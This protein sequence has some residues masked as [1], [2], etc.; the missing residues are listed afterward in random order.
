MTWV[1][2][3]KKEAVH[4][5]EKSSNPQSSLSSEA[6]VYRYLRLASQAGRVTL[7]EHEYSK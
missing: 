1:S 6:G 4:A 7:A 5:H 2:E 3:W